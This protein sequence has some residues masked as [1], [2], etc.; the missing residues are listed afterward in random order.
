[1]RKLIG[2]L[3]LFACIILVVFI[4]GCTKSI[5][6][7]RDEYGC[8]NTAGYTWCE[9][10]QKC[11]RTWVEECPSTEMTLEEAIEIAQN[12]DCV[13]E[14]NLTDESMYN[15]ATKTWWIDLDIEKAGCAPACV[16]NV[17]TKQAEINWRCTGLITN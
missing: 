7:D 10:K 5:G 2:L 11:L 1:M 6:G 15:N 17:E 14:G 4:S 12:S 8:L 13:K 9:S 16:I 3:G